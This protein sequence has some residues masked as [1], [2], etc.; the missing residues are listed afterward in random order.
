MKERHC[1]H[2]FQCLFS[3]PSA[4]FFFPF[5]PG[6]IRAAG[7]LAF[8]AHPGHILMY[9]PGDSLRRRLPA[10]RMASGKRCPGL[11]EDGFILSG[12]DGYPPL[13]TYSNFLNSCVKP[14]YW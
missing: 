11:K 14:G 2:C 10:T 13:S 6:A 8:L 12:L 7:A 9:A 5:F 4:G 3:Q 1:S